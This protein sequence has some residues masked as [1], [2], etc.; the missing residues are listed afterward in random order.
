[1]HNAPQVEVV[2]LG[3]AKEQ[4]KGWFFKPLSEVH[5]TAPTRDPL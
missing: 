1:M 2:D 3:D 5:P 4:T